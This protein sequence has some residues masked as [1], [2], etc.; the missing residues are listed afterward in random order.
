MTYPELAAELKALRVT[1][2][3]IYRAS[4]YLDYL[5]NA[6]TFFQTTLAVNLGAANYSFVQT[7]V[8][9]ASLMN[10]MAMMFDLF[11]GTAVDQALSLNIPNN[12]TYTQ[13]FDT[14]ILNN[15]YPANLV[16]F[17]RTFIVSTGALQL[18]YNHFTGNIEQ[19]CRRMYADKALLEAF[20]DALTPNTIHAI[21]ELTAI[22]STG[23]DFHKGGTQVLILAFDVDVVGLFDYNPVTEIKR[24]VYKPSDIEADCLLAGRSDVVNAVVPGFMTASLFEIYNAQLAAYKATHPG[25]TGL[26]VPVYGILP[27]NYQSLHPAGPPLPV[28]AAYGYI[29]FLNNDLSGTSIQFNGY[30][31]FAQ[32]DYLIFKSQDA[33]AITRTFYRT[34]G[35]IA[36]L[37][38]SF[39]IQDLHL[40]NLRVKTYLPY[41][42]DM[43]ISLNKETNSIGATSLISGLGMPIGGI[44]GLFLNAQDFTWVTPPPAATGNNCFLNRR[45]E[46]DYKENRLWR[47]EGVRNKQYVPIDQ[48]ALLTGFTDGMTVLRAAQQNLAFNDWFDRLNNVVVRYIPYATAE[49]KNSFISP[50]YFDPSNATGQLF[51]M[52]T[53]VR[54]RLEVDASNYQEP[55]LPNF[56]VLAGSQC[57]DDL[58]QLD[59]PIYYYRIG[60]QQIVDSIGAQV[61]ITPSVT[62]DNPDPPPPTQQ[63]PVTYPLPDFFPNIPTDVVIDQQQVQA[64]GDARYPAR[65]LLLQTSITN[66][67]HVEDVS[68]HDA[69]PVN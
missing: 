27:R 62:I 18:L 23:S 49:F 60:M 51:T 39:S 12:Q 53:L 66:S 19:A 35:A 15:D 43:E 61:Q 7:A 28:R 10:E 4:L 52:Q 65:L 22:K 45:Y 48:P 5:Q 56:Y 38:C 40:E 30:Y 8:R 14:N 34:E 64:L 68:L 24:L 46:T 69:L 41:L 3:D 9:S 67:L 21:Q 50:Y 44:N 36:A 6:Q 63:L 37:A 31:P 42:I 26:P 32:S 57:L 29:E 59:I 17:R 25:F 54:G 33:A 58:N 20:F 47:W 13:Y 55:D 16:D 2:P 11:I 1:P